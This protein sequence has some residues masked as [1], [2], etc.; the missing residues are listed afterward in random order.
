MILGSF[1]GH[2]MYRTAL[3]IITV[4]G[5]MSLVILYLAGV[6]YQSGNVELGQAFTVM[7]YC[8]Y[9]GITTAGLVIFF[10]LWQRPEGIALFL[11]FLSALA[12]L[13]A[14]YLPYR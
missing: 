13:T 2:H 7:R 8:A 14:F 1:D 6:G 12:G 10:M 3:P 9:G 4:L 5:F 11:L